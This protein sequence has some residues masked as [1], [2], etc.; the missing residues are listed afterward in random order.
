[1][2]APSTLMVMVQ[3]GTK[4]VRRPQVKAEGRDG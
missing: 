3:D 4:E 1:M 2:L